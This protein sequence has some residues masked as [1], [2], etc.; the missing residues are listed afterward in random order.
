MQVLHNL[1]QIIAFSNDP[2]PPT[3]RCHLLT[4][5]FS[6]TNSD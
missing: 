2:I 1:T 4:N 6:N 5:L 3:T